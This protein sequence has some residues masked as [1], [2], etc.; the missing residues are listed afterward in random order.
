[1]CPHAAWTQF[2]SVA[3]SCPT[4]CD[5]VDYSTPGLPV[6]HQL[7]EFPQ[8]HV[9]WVSDAIQPSHP[10][11]S[12]VPF[13]SCL[14]SFPASGSLQMSQF[15]ASGGQSIG[16]SATE[17]Q[18]NIYFC[19]IDYAKA[20]DCVD[21]NKLWTQC[22]GTDSLQSSSNPWELGKKD[23]CASHCPEDRR[24]RVTHSWGLIAALGGVRLADLWKQEAELY[25]Y[26]CIYPVGSVP[27]KN[28]D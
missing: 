11:I 25:I 17:F 27:L 23:T 4:V 5:P 18:K 15:F 14:Q 10:T 2:G 21:H 20:F 24:Q 13:S 7:P 12:F 6:H 16:V 1:M 8:T 28:P 3:Q 9:Y 26:L 19:F 22:W